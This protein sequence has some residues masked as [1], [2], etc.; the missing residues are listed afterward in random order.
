MSACTGSESQVAK[1]QLHTDLS[2]G[3]LGLG[4]EPP[5]SACVLEVDTLD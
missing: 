5:L 2:L 3:L 1:A 4:A